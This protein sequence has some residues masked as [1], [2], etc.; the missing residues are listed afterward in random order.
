MVSEYQKDMLRRAL[1]E[2]NLLSEGEKLTGLAIHL[3]TEANRLAPV[4]RNRLLYKT[5]HLGAAIAMRYPDLGAQMVA[6]DPSAA[7]VAADIKA[8]MD[9]ALQQAEEVARG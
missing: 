6:G 8:G 3:I 7:R 9:L 1:D 2:L 4:D 5:L